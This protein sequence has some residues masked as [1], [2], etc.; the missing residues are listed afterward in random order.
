MEKKNTNLCQI[1]EMKC[2]LS[3][4]GRHINHVRLSSGLAKALNKSYSHKIYYLKS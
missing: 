2:I 4:N 1:N 3:S